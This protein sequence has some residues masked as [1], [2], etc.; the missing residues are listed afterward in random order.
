MVETE[1][2]EIKMGYDTIS[3]KDAVNNIRNNTYLLPAIQREM[4]WDAEQIENLFDSAIS[5]YPL[6][7]M[8]FWKCDPSVLKNYKFYHFLKKYD[9]Q[10]ENHC[11]VYSTAGQSE[12]T[13]IL[14]GQQRLTAFYLGLCSSLKL[15]KART[16]WEDPSNFEEH[17]YILICSINNSR[18]RTVSLNSVSRPSSK[19]KKKTKKWW[20]FLV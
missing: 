6:G 16:K 10:N 3:I 11:V 4:V 7:L 2:G 18:M 14:D 20:S 13:G 15:H 12:V 17:F 1:K 9:E 8:L 19:L 5:G